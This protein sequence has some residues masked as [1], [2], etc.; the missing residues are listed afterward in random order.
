MTTYSGVYLDG[1][2][3]CGS[4]RPGLLSALPDTPLVRV[5]IQTGIQRHPAW[6]LDR[7]AV[8]IHAYAETSLKHG[9]PTI[10]V[11]AHGT[12]FSDVNASYVVL[13]SVTW[14][15]SQRVR[16]EAERVIALMTA[17]A[18][19]SA[20]PRNEEIFPPVDPSLLCALSNRFVG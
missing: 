7:L 4:V 14:H 1:M 9:N 10:Q 8:V 12:L 16:A 19:R 11:N 13:R 3:D 18:S 6:A 15:T 17:S 5:S 20:W 2:L